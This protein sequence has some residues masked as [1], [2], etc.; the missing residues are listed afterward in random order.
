[1]NRGS[2]LERLEVA[3]QRLAEND[4]NRTINYDSIYQRLQVLEE[5]TGV[6]SANGASSSPGA[7]SM[8]RPAG[9]TCAVG[10]PQVHAL[11]LSVE[12]NPVLRAINETL[13]FIVQA[14]ERQEKGIAVLSSALTREG[15]KRPAPVVGAPNAA[16]AKKKAARR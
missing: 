7:G 1:M 15:A 6:G 4:A 13:R 2:I 14:M 11:S 5:I 9:D 3:E 10:P 8:T 12:E 16:P